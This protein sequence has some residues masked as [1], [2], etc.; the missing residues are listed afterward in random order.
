M[1]TW[2]RVAIAGTA[3]IALL[4][5]TGAVSAEP[6]PA[7]GTYLEFPEQ[8]IA[9]E[10]GTDC[11]STYAIVDAQTEN[12]GD[13]YDGGGV[14]YV[15]GQNLWLTSESVDLTQEGGQTVITGDFVT[16]DGV[17]HRFELRWLAPDIVRQTLWMTNSTLEDV[18]IEV[19]HSS[20]WGADEETIYD[21]SSGDDELGTDDVW[22]AAY[23][24]EW[25]D[26]SIPAVV[27]GSG[28]DVAS[29]ILDLAPSSVDSCAGYEGATATY[30]VT[31]PAGETR[32]MVWF[33][34]VT[35][36]GVGEGWLAG[37]AGA[38][39]AVADDVR[40]ELIAKLQGIVSGF[41]A[42]SSLAAGLDLSLVVNWAP[43]V[44]AAPVTP[45]TPVEP[46]TPVTPT[47]AAP[48]GAAAPAQAVRATPAYT[49]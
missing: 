8:G 9:W 11:V 38:G 45:V 6:S 18:T 40:A 14:I 48:G 17:D 37:G 12:N 1:N 35:D 30:E 3:G 28:G 39:P 41:T 20:N 47:P 33:L 44:P 24:G 32:I 46:V 25:A 29:P 34:T 13:A 15:N 36:P 10:T 42:S 7:D 23:E 19:Q 49:G 21:T 43:A 5:G 16:V 22:L 4:A 31:I 26:D 27:Y 2:G